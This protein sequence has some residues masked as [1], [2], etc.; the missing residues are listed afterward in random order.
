MCVPQGWEEACCP[1]LSEGSAFPCVGWA[2]N[3]GRREQEASDWG[4]AFLCSSAALPWHAEPLLLI[5]L[6]PQ[7]WKL[8]W[9]L[10][11]MEMV[12]AGRRGG[13][14]SRKSRCLFRVM[15]SESDLFL[16]A[17]SG[18]G[19][20]RGRRGWEKGKRKTGKREKEKQRRKEKGREEKLYRMDHMIFSTA[21]LWTCSMFQHPCLPIPGEGPLVSLLANFQSHINAPP[22]LS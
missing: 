13:A 21:P 8:V 11:A 22:L 18:A 3:L 2:V 16:W 19:E 15:V 7:G 17:S 4:S 9:K 5:Y 14:L 12:C 20:Q 6:P 10:P 1:A